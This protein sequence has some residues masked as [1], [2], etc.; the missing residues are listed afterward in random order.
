MNTSGG[1]GG[2][3]SDR[4]WNRY[5]G[6]SGGGIQFGLWQTEIYDSLKFQILNCATSVYFG[7]MVTEI[8]HLDVLNRG[9]LNKVST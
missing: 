4:G 1:I 5:S 3:I 8:A 6:E 9:G 2:G 7:S